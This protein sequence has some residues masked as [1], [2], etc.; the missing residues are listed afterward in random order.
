M[1][2]SEAVFNTRGVASLAQNR[3]NCATGMHVVIDGAM[4]ESMD[5]LLPGDAGALGGINLVQPNDIEAIE[6]Y[7]DDIEIPANLPSSYCGMIYI[8]TK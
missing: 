6:I 4:I 3:A 8:W 1:V 5:E 2:G 7:K